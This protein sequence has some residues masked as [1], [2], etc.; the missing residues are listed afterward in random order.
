VEQAA[1]EQADKHIHSFKSGYFYVFRS[2]KISKR[3]GRNINAKQ[4]R[5]T[6]RKGP[7]AICITTSRRR[8]SAEPG[9][10][11]IEW[12]LGRL[13]YEWLHVP[14]MGLD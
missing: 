12:Q 3:C 4:E 6:Q 5:V 13:P 2:S 9:V 1:D 14:A 10:L 11:G 8:F 7:H